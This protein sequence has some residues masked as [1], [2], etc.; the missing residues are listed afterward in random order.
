MVC[1][2]LLSANQKVLVIFSYFLFF[3]AMYGLLLLNPCFIP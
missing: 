3:D 1:V 2:Y